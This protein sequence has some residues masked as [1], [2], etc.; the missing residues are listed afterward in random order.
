LLADSDARVTDLTDDAGF[1]ADKFYA[2][3]FSQ[4]DFAQACLN[5]RG[6]G[7][8]ANANDITRLNA[9]E[10]T[11]LRPGAL[12]VQNFRWLRMIAH[13]V[14]GKRA[15]R[16]IQYRTMTTACAFLSEACGRCPADILP[17]E[18]LNPISHRLQT[19]GALRSKRSAALQERRF[20]GETGNLFDCVQSHA[21]ARFLAISSGFVND[22]DFDCFVERGGDGAQCG[23]GIFLFSA[24]ERGDVFFLKAAEAGLDAGVVQVLPR[25]V[26]HAAFG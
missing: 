14:N 13:S 25:A 19:G 7:Q 12:A 17:A 2:L 22:A 24:S 6:R 8:L 10:R 26:A 1:V 15:R 5:F 9:T 11:Q 23:G 16:R 21:E 3:P 20:I 4:P 18:S